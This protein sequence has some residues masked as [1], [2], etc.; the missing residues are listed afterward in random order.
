MWLSSEHSWLFVAIW[1]QVDW[2]SRHVGRSCFL[3][4][5]TYIIS[6]TVWT[7]PC[8]CCWLLLQMDSISFCCCCSNF[9]P[10][11]LLRFASMLQG[12]T[13]FSLK[14]VAENQLCRPYV[15]NVSGTSLWRS[16]SILPFSVWMLRRELNSLP[17]WW[18]TAMASKLLS[19]AFLCNH[20]HVHGSLLQRKGVDIYIKKCFT[21]LRLYVCGKILVLPPR[22]NTDADWITKLSRCFCL[23]LKAA[24]TCTLC[25]QCVC[26]LCGGLQCPRAGPRLKYTFVQKTNQQKKTFK[27]KKDS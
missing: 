17:T 19:T 10:L 16:S 14:P 24:C 18:N 22:V 9:C 11:I 23:C 4:S 7:P 15:S 6:K 20:C 21:V 2:T 8:G 13:C 5:Q 26:G 3:S 12:G 27:D 25:I 1:I